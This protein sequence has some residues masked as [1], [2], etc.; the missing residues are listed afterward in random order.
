MSNCH[1]ESSLNQHKFNVSQLCRLEFLREF[2]CA[3][4]K[5]QAGLCCLEAAGETLSLSFLPQ[6]CFPGFVPPPSSNIGPNSSPYYS[7]VLIDPPTSEDTCHPVGPTQIMQ[8]DNLSNLISSKVISPSSTYNLILSPTSPSTVDNSDIKTSFESNFMLSLI[9]LCNSF[10][11][12]FCLFKPTHQH[13]RV[14]CLDI[15][16]KAYFTLFF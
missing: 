6:S 4:A 10:L 16:A 2:P 9:S 13:R 5:V 1:T 15:S 7:L 11:K 8:Q 14:Q 12:W 3:E